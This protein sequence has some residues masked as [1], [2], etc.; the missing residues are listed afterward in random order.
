MVPCVVPSHNY[1]GV[2]FNPD[3]IK[4]YEYMV[5]T[6]KPVCVNPEVNLNI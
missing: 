5:N 1:D 4:K 2:A 3:I 6:Y